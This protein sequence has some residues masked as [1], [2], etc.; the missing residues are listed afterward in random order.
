[1]QIKTNKTHSQD[2][3][4]LVEMI[5]SLAVLAILAA[6]LIP[7]LTG[8]IDKARQQSIIAETRSVVMAAQVVVSEDYGQNSAI[9]NSN[10]YLTDEVQQEI[11]TLAEASGELS[12]FVIQGSDGATAEQPAGKVI[13]LVYTKDGVSCQYS[14]AG[15]ELYT[16][17][18]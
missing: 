16:I 10:T 4:T 15:D 2:G 14:F 17:L 9:A 7:S 13:E 3:F 11:L 18:P 12:N 8:Y 5:V 1:M 6:F